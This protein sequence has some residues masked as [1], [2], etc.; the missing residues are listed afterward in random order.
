VPSAVP[1]TTLVPHPLLVATD[2]R[3]HSTAPTT[4]TPSVV[5]Q[6]DRWSV[7]V[8]VVVPLVAGG[9]RC[10]HHRSFP[11]RTL[12]TNGDCDR[13]HRRTEA[14]GPGILNILIGMS[15]GT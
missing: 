4:M 7:A 11:Y 13:E 12:M 1:V 15:L 9:C 3:A 10:R 2:I 14:Q 5:D 6:F 8:F